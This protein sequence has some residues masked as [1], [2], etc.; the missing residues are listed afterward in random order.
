[1]Y[2]W[3]QLLEPTKE[4]S[5]LQLYADI[6][7]QFEKDIEEWSLQDVKSF[8]ISNSPNTEEELKNLIPI[9]GVLNSYSYE[10]DATVHLVNPY[11]GKFYS[12]YGS[13]C[14]CYGFE[15][16]FNLEE[17]PIQYLMTLEYAEHIRKVI[18]YFSDRPSA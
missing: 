17:T 11:T 16:Q 6:P 5:V 15:G 18:K 1:M 4:L 9:L 2:D 14:S 12:V 10:E 7:T 13:H 3:K 8:V